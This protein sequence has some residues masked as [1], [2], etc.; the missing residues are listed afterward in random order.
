MD[1]TLVVN[2]LPPEFINNLSPDAKN[3]VSQGGVYRPDQELQHFVNTA[4]HPTKS[5][6]FKKTAELFNRLVEL[7]AVTG[8]FSMGSVTLASGITP[9]YLS[10]PLDLGPDTYD[11][12]FLF[13]YSCYSRDELNEL[14][15]ADG[16]F[17]REGEIGNMPNW[18]MPGL[19]IRKTLAESIAEHKT[20]DSDLS[21]GNIP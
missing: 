16:K 7:G 11:A 15:V 9:L 3:I 13:F 8:F 4:Q 5:W 14:G 1:K 12:V 21:N 19:R 18:A 2:S 17:L 10:E 20:P 6:Y